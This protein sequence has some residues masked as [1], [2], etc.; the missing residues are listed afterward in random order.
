M[1]FGQERQYNIIRNFAA[2][3]E[4]TES[5]LVLLEE[6]LDKNNTALN[7][8][9]E[10]RIEVRNQIKVLID[11]YEILRK[12]SKIIKKQIKDLE[13]RK[14][15]LA[16]EIKTV[17]V[18]LDKFVEKILKRD[19]ILSAQFAKINRR[20]SRYRQILKQM[21]KYSKEI[22]DL[23][24]EDYNKLRE[25]ITSRFETLLTDMQYTKRH[26]Y[27]KS[28]RLEKIDKNLN[29]IRNI[30]SKYAKVNKKMPEIINEVRKEEKV[31]QDNFLKT[32]T[33]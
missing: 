11:T 26:L 27:T 28:K 4:T 19:S 16:T 12:N 1:S 14:K 5:K 20:N 13:T 2:K 32:V 3:I 9:Q 7:D 21:R 17:K 10:S 25:E 29:N 15:N 18:K 24:P 6:Q 23:V 30:L 22:Q 8:M 33:N 31:R